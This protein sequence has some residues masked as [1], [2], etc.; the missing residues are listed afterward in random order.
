MFFYAF[1]PKARGGEEKGEE[2][3]PYP[4]VMPVALLE[5]FQKDLLTSKRFVTK[6]LSEFWLA[7]WRGA[8]GLKWFDLKRTPTH[9]QARP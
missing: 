8:G 9:K 1:R 2:K 6:G 5:S 3:D 7:S 4:C